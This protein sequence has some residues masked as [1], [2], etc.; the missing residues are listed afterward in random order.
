MYKILSKSRSRETED[1]DRRRD[2]TEDVIRTE[3]TRVTRRTH[4]HTQ[5]LLNRVQTQRQDNGQRRQRARQGDRGEKKEWEVLSDISYCPESYNPCY[6]YH[7]LTLYNICLA[8]TLC[9]TPF[10]I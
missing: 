2:K 3:E 8:S 5:E 10:H 4:T 1:R 9:S 7:C 6:M